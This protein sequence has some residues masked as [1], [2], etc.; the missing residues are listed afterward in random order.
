MGVKRSAASL[1]NSSYD[2]QRNM[3]LGRSLEYWQGSSRGSSSSNS[4]GVDYGKISGSSSTV[5]GCKV[6]SS[7]IRQ[8][9]IQ[10]RQKPAVAQASLEYWHGSSRGDCSSCG[11]NNSSCGSNDSCCRTL[12]RQSPSAAAAAGS[13]T[14]TWQQQTPLQQW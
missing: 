12:S 4:S 7:L 9:L 1:G 13:S 2:T 6:V 14:C 3:Q 11:G 8:E 5:Y 10:H